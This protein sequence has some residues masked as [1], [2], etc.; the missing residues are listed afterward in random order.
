MLV[1]LERQQ[2]LVERG[3]AALGLLTRRFELDDAPGAPLVRFA[4]GR[5]M[6]PKL[7]NVRRRLLLE[8]VELA[9]LLQAPAV[10]VPP[11][12]ES[13]ERDPE[14]DGREGNDL[15]ECRRQAGQR[16]AETLAQG[17]CLLLEPFRIRSFLVSH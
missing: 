12:A 3:R 2:A 11:G 1:R 13:D 10:L 16:L 4:D 7:G 14:N 9:R 15:R 17:R 5:R 6:R 8:L